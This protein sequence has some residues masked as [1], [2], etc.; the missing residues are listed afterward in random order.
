MARKSNETEVAIVPDEEREEQGCSEPGPS[1]IARELE[2]IKADTIAAA[3]KRSH[4]PQPLFWSLFH[5][6]LAEIRSA[7]KTVRELEELFSIK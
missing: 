4:L 1:D 3:D 2:R 7:K 6:R 5:S